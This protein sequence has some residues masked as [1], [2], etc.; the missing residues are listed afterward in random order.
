MID[1][2]TALQL[3][4]DHAARLPPK[5]VPLDEAAGLILAEDVTSGIDSPPY[6]KALMDGYAVVASDRTPERA[7][8][9]SVAAGEVPRHAVIPGTAMRIMTGAPVPEGA[10]AVVRIED[11]QSA[12]DGSTVTIGMPAPAPGKNILRR[13]V[14]LRAGELLLK[15]GAWLR[16]I[17]I[18]L[19]AEAGHAIVLVVP[20]PKVGVLSTGNELVPVESALAPGEIR[21][22]NG[23]M[24]VAAAAD[25]GAEPRALDIGRDD[26]AQLRDLVKQGLEHNLL[27]VSGGVSAGD[28][29]LV[30]AVLKE[31]GVTEVF[32]KIAL[33]PGKPLWF[34]I[35]KQSRGD[36]TLVFGLP[37][38]PVS[39]LVCFEV[40][41]RPA[42][43][44]LAGREFAGPK[45]IPAALA[46]PYE[47]TGGRASYLPAR[48][49]PPPGKPPSAE[50]LPS[51]KLLPW[52]GSA[53]LAALRQ[54][55]CFVS[56]P[57]ESV[58][59]ATGDTIR[60]LRI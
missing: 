4:K 53:D 8:I 23:P 30:P 60:V 21:N 13:G 22:S 5:R 51:V 20:R 11:T 47:H 52:Q 6:D 16:A 17:E 9:A 58:K 44:A 55:N 36:T 39:S 2:E 15:S 41:V 28:F 40:F 24:L 48:L 3:V 49:E 42:I 54:A 59:L 45:M 19:L 43:A 12:E 35:Q 38:N 29:D 33:R 46:H 32:H 14:A 1:V 37:G 57:G 50:R 56:L 7:I 34:G 31:V 18:A 25:A 26:R 10:D 27:L